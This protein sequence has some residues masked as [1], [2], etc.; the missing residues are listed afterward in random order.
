MVVGDVLSGFLV[1]LRQVKEGEN[2]S[3]LMEGY[4]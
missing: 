2:W 1:G 3:V 4:W